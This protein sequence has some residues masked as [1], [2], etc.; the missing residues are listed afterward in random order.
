MIKTKRNAA[1]NCMMNFSPPLKIKYMIKNMSGI[2]I[3]MAILKNRADRKNLFFLNIY[4]LAS[5]KARAIIL[6]WQFMSS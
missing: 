1:M 5:I 2:Y 3:T 6:F 4:M